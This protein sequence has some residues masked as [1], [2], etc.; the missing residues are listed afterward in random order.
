MNKGITFV[1]RVASSFLKQIKEYNEED[2]IV[3]INI[4]KEFK[5]IRIINVVLPTGEVEKLITNL[6]DKSF[7]PNDFKDLYFRRWGIE[8]RYN[9]LKN[10]LEIEN[11]TGDTELTVCQDFYATIYL[12]NLYETIKSCCDEAIDEENQNKELKYKYQTNTKRLISKLKDNLIKVVIEDNHFRKEKMLENL[13][14]Q[15]KKNA[16]PIIP[17]RSFPRKK[18]SESI[19]F[20]KNKKRSW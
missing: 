2:G 3:Q 20:S 15:I 16:I 1:M 6:Y 13:I 10:R 19:K 4:G 5:D 7:S 12:S 8:T 9:F 14:S 17:D 11:F 18:N